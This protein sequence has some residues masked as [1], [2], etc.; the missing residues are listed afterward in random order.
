MILSVHQDAS[1]RH[2]LSP[3]SPVAPHLRCDSVIPFNTGDFSSW[4]PG[5]LIALPSCGSHVVV[6]SSDHDTTE[7]RM[8]SASDSSGKLILIQERIVGLRYDVSDYRGNL[9]ILTNE[10]GATDFK[11]RR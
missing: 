1:P 6:Q 9:I 3:S 7:I 5:S 2:V 8:I 10:G 4:C 11:V